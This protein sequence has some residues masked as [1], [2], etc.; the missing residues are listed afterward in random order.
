MAGDNAQQIEDWNGLLGQR[1]AEEQAYLDRLTGPFGAA[2]LKAASPQAGER[3]I[4]I[5]CGCG[6]TTLDLARAVG[7]SGTVLGVDVS[8]PMLAVARQR[9]EAS[10]LANA[11]FREADASVATLPGK[12]DLLF[13]RFG[14]MFFDAPHAAFAHLRRALSDDGRLAF[15]CWRAPRDNPWA[16]V[17]LSAGRSVVPVPPDAPA[18][19][20][21]APG[22]FAFA[23]ASR[24]R[25]ILLEAGFR[26]VDATAVESPVYLGASPASAAQGVARMGPLS[27]HIRDYGVDQEDTII[28][29]V[30]R[31][32]AR[33]AVA[34]G[35]VSLAGA[36]W[37]VTAKAG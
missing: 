13:S 2:A 22:P 34:D 20:P 25:A 5:G 8:R 21:H 9:A 23:D 1:W 17:P 26:D 37:V 7:P 6:D 32:L 4:D 16:M 11:E 33:H 31:E 14:V 3:V 29:A 18:M 35:S 12:Q 27:R 10:G 24:V 36:C 30:E 15:V 28:A 19:D